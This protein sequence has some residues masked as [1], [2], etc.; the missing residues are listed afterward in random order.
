MARCAIST[1]IFAWNGRRPVKSWNLLVR[2]GSELRKSR[3]HSVTIF[4]V[5]SSAGVKSSSVTSA[6]PMVTPASTPKCRTGWKFDRQTMK[7]PAVS[8]SA[9]YTAACPAERIA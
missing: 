1:T 9:M 4:V 5:A 7:N 6:T 3:S 8:A 2:L